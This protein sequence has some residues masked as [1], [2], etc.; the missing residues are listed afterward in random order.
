VAADVST[1]SG[2]LV[3]AAT[4]VAASVILVAAHAGAAD[5]AAV[6]QTVG[7]MS[8]AEAPVPAPGS[9]VPTLLQ[10]A[11]L[12]LAAGGGI[13]VGRSWVSTGRAG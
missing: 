6:P 12:A 11:G 10:T 2:R 9:P 13:T 3:A 5:R 1:V 4:I 8:F 7:P